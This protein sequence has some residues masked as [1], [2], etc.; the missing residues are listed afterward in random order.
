VSVYVQPLDN[1]TITDR[2]GRLHVAVAVTN[3]SPRPFRVVTASADADPL[4]HRMEV[5]LGKRP[6]ADE[7]AAGRQVRPSA[8]VVVSL[9]LSV[10]PGCLEQEEVGIG[11]KV[12]AGHQTLHTASS[13]KVGLRGVGLPRC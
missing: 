1:C 9:Q 2:Q 10:A 8:D 12:R 11:V 7:P 3:L 6:C 13:T 4:L 5:R